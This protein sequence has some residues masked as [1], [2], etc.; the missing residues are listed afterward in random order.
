MYNEFYLKNLNSCSFGPSTIGAISIKGLTILERTN[1]TFKVMSALKFPSSTTYTVEFDKDYKLTKI[2]P[3]ADN[4]TTIN[5]LFCIS[6][7][8]LSPILQNLNS[9][10]FS[11]VDDAYIDSFLKEL[12][13]CNLNGEKLLSCLNFL[14]KLGSKN[15]STLLK[16]YFKCLEKY[17]LYEQLLDTCNDGLLKSKNKEI[18]LT[19]IAEFFFLISS[20]DKNVSTEYITKIN[21]LI[22][23]FSDEEFLSILQNQVR[24]NVLLTS[25]FSFSSKIDSLL[26][27]EKLIT[28]D[29]LIKILPATY[30]DRIV[31]DGPLSYFT[32][33]LLISKKTKKE[34]ENYLSKHFIFYPASLQILFENYQLV[35][36]ICENSLYT[37]LLT[38]LCRY[39]DKSRES[40]NSKYPNALSLLYYMVD[41]YKECKDTVCTSITSSTPNTF[42]SIFNCLIDNE[43]KEDKVTIYNDIKENMLV[44]C[45]VN[46]V[47]KILV[48]MSSYYSDYFLVLYEACKDDENLNNVFINVVLNS[49]FPIDALFKNNNVLIESI[50]KTP[51]IIALE[52]SG[53]LKKL[54]IK[55][56]DL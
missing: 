52:N 26:K 21:S 46:L 44:Y 14:S 55:E 37:P 24:A 13:S 1:N 5:I 7:H 27:N 51:L 33:T 29:Q 40:I 23:K 34:T 10:K 38:A 43:T 53:I 42:Y 20:D 30:V 17:Y 16:T 50:I 47:G 6:N 48:K 31:S 15:E 49:N 9:D 41:K 25:P 18:R 32:L 12:I 39:V 2:T 45:P 19:I 4:I 22:E 3:S 28:V 11:K 35:D 8:C 54:D 56:V 36:L